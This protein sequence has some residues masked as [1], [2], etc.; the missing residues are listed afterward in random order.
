M[1]ATAADASSN[2]NSNSNSNNNN[3]SN[4]NAVISINIT[5]ESIRR[6]LSDVREIMTCP[7]TDSGIYYVH[8]EDDVL[9]GHAMLHGRPGTA[10]ADGYYFF[11]IKFPP[12]YPHAP[13]S[14]TF[15]TN[16][17]ETRM[18]PNF[19]K[20]GYVCLSI[21]NNWK[22]EQ[23]TGCLTLKSVLLTMVSIMD[24]KPL[25]HEPGIRESHAD[26]SPYHRIIE[27]K[28]IEFA[29]CRLLNRTDFD[30]YIIL[31]AACK[32]YFYERMCELFTSGR[33]QI[34]ERVRAL[35]VKYAAAFAAAPASNSHVLNVAIYKMQCVINY[36]TLT[37]FVESVTV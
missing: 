16:D 29:C 33:D 3:N 26:F 35:K 19:Y 15:L 31:P 10:Y 24:E 34:L 14:V 25:L 12:D 23:W 21:L 30:R 5:K 6:I 27:Y 11:R 28:T 17:G 18:H 36:D 1:A 7:L 2:N 8:D 4:S 20:T 13:L 37:D 9:L 32:P 22:G